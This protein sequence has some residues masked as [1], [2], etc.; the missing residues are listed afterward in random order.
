MY[1]DFVHLV[2]YS[3]QGVNQMNEIWYAH[4]GWIAAACL[5]S[6]AI[7]GIFSGLLRWRR[8]IF[9][10]PYI[11]LTL[12]FLYAYLQWS[13]LSVVTLLRHN[14]VWGVVGA[15]ILSIITIKNVLSQPASPRSKGFRLA[16]DLLWSGFLYGLTDALLLSVLPVLA[17]WQAF[18]LLGWTINA[19]GRILMSILAI[20]ASILVT[21]AY[22]VGYLEFRGKRMITANVGNSVMTLGYLLTSNPLAAMI[23]HSAMHMTAVLH[24]PARVVQLPPHDPA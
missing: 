20:L 16:F 8:D 17:T 23:C 5:I 1:H 19:P 18:T 3:A 24:G 2:I 6:F 4:L 13:G 9:L 7:S 11:G 15:G 22:H 12:L 10:A 21:S 14:W